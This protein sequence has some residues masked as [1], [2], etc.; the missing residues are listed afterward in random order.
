M[1]RKL[2]YLIVVLLAC[3]V[4]P[5]GFVAAEGEAPAVIDAPAGEID[6]TW[7]EETEPNDTPAQATQMAYGSETGGTLANA[8]AVDYLKFSGHAGDQVAFAHGDHSQTGPLTLIAPSGATVPLSG[9]FNYGAMYATLPTTGVYRI[10]IDLPEPFYYDFERYYYGF[11]LA[12]LGV[13]EPNDTRETAIQVQP[14]QAVRGMTD[15]PCDNDWYTFQGRAGDAFPFVWPD[16]SYWDQPAYFLYDAAGNPMWGV[17][18]L[19]ADGTY[20]I[21]FFGDWADDDDGGCLPGGTYGF[22]SGYPLWVSA[23]VDNLGGNTAI[24]QQDIAMRANAAGKWQLVFD[25]SDV[26]ITQ[27]L[28]AMERLDDGSILMSLGASQT[29]PGLGKVMPQDIIRFIPTLLGPTTAGTFEWYLDGSDVGLTTTGEKIDAINTVKDSNDPNQLVISISG[30]GSV[31]RQSGGSLTVQD[32]DL[33]NFVGTGYGANSS[34]KWRM[35][36][37]GSTVPGMAAEDINASTVWLHSRFA[38][39]MLSFTD[40]FTVDGVSG[41]PRDVF[42]M[43]D[44][45]PAS[46]VAKNLTN[47]KLDA[48]TVGVRPDVILNRTVFSPTND[49]FVS[50]AAPNAV[51]NSDRLDVASSPD[52]RTAYLKF[53]LTGLSGYVLSAKLRLHTVD[54]AT[55]GGSLCEVSPYYLNTTSLWLET[56][57]TWANAPLPGEYWCWVPVG[58]VEAG[59]WIDIDV[60]YHVQDALWNGGRASFAIQTTALDAA[61][62]SS[63]EGAQPPELIVVT[64]P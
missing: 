43:E 39:L 54:S 32:E 3:F 2:A 37:D 27:D 6:W 13:D 30:A 4:L 19:P 55:S 12:K 11:Y 28:V 41:G 51:F 21:Q 18:V 23:D 36:L 62:Y 9:P 16:H 48:L 38:R 29:V 25:A 40:S 17:N 44:R 60:T 8:D 26:G 24:K 52:V 45:F 59:G 56:G 49:A 20:Y 1:N 31:P 33:I 42:G 7:V 22:E 46:L 34:G 50:S 47:V 58:Q 61:A 10:R 64:E 35:N 5:A 14:L 53:N 15:Y 63:K 57:L